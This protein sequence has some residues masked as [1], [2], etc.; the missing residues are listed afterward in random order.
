MQEDR[1]GIVVDEIPT[2]LLKN[3][4][5]DLIN[6]ILSDATTDKV[7]VDL[8]KKIIYLWRQDSLASP[9]GVRALYEAAVLVNPETLSGIV[10]RYGLESLVVSI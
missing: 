9:D 8:A 5:K 4:A 2:S 1:Y 7:P 10:R 3:F 6:I